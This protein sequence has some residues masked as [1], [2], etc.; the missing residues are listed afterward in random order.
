MW[1]TAIG[2]EQGPVS[3]C[4]Y[5]STVCSEVCRSASAFYLCVNS[6]VNEQPTVVYRANMTNTVKLAYTL[7]ILIHVHLHILLFLP[8]P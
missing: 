7:C 1:R 8:L 2:L 6:Y 4:T 5:L 3:M